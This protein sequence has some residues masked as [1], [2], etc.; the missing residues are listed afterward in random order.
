MMNKQVARIALDVPKRITGKRIRFLA[1]ARRAKMPKKALVFAC[2]FL[3]IASACQSQNAGL[4]GSGQPAG[5]SSPAADKPVEL[6]FWYAYGGNLGKASEELVNQFNESQNKIRV[7]AQFQ[8]ANYAALNSKLQAAVVAG[9]AP[10]VTVIENMTTG[11]FV[12]AGILQDLTPFIERDKPD[13]DDFVPIMLGNSYVDGRFY[14]FPYLRSTNILYFNATLVKEAG[15]DPA[16]PK[17]WDELAAYARKLNVPGQRSGIT[18]VIDMTRFETFLQ[19]A[20]GSMLSADGK[21]TVFASPEGAAVLNFWLGL[22]REGV[23]DLPYTENAAD[24]VRQN[25]VNQRAAMFVQSTSWITTLSESFAQSGAELGATVIP[26]KVNHGSTSLGSNIAMLAKLPKEKQ[27]A[28]WTFIRWMTD[29]E[30]TVTSSLISG[31]QPTRKSAIESD[32]MQEAYRT[33]RLFRVASEQ[34][35]M[36]AARSMVLEYNE[37]GNVLETHIQKSLQDDAYSAQAALA[38]AAKQA[39]ALLNK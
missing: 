37:I 12:V 26:A 7:T 6:K 25:F 14:A 15:L 33:N 19:S 38:N 28:A 39:N 1:D 9:N 22:K 29:T 2:A 30:Q 20:G 23:A 31:Y 35:A 18:A 24:N 10:D 17:T 5:A 11:P 34:M 27:E 32:R 13:L 16:G 4:N 21:Q 3:L 36:A 8:G